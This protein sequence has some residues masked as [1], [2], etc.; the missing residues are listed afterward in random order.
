MAH[1]LAMLE[2]WFKYLIIREICLQ[3]LVVS[4]NNSYF[5]VFTP[6]PCVQ[7]RRFV[8]FFINFPV[9][10]KTKHIFYNTSKKI[11]IY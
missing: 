6:K 8:L 5:V 3:A 4:G 7:H 2:I 10:I 11:L 1:D 9:F